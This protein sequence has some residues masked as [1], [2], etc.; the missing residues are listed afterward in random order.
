LETAEAFDAEMGRC[1]LGVYRS[2]RD[3]GLAP[4]RDRLPAASARPGLI[5]IPTG[6]EFTGGEALH[7]WAAQQTDAQVAVLEGLGHWWMLEN[8]AAGAEALTRFWSTI[9]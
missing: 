9:E 7:R 2:I 4:W 5:L 8:P 1:I 6:D 3:D